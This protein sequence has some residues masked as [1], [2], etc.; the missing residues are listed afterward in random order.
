MV[1]KDKMSENGNEC[2]EMLKREKSSVEAVTF[3][4]QRYDD[5][6]QQPRR[7]GVTFW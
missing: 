1:G 2:Q 6:A 4:T 3:G 5:S 7:A